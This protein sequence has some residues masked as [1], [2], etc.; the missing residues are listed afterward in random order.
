MGFYKVFAYIPLL[1]RKSKLLLVSPINLAA[2]LDFNN[3]LSGEKDYLHSA[4]Q[5]TA[6][7]KGEHDHMQQ[8][9]SHFVDQW[10]ECHL[11]LVVQR[12]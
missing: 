1:Q 12:V 2:I 4:L 9:F 6:P 10:F 3:S 7:G 8:G 11:S 5:E